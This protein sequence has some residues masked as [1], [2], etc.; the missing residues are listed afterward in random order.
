M[1]VFP[2]GESGPPALELALVA[3]DLDWRGALGLDAV[4][5]EQDAAE[6]AA[7]LAGAGVDGL[8]YVTQQSEGRCRLRAL[9]IPSLEWAKEPPEDEGFCRFTVEDDGALHPGGARGVAATPSGRLT[10]VL[11]GELFA[12]YPGDRSELLLSAARLEEIV[13]S[14]AA[15]EEVAW[16]DDERFWAVV[17]TGESATVALMTAHGLLGAPWFGAPSVSGLQLSSGGMAAVSSDRGV[18]FFDRGGRRV[19][20]FTNGRDV[21]W[22]P[23][24]VIA[25]ISTPREVIFV[26]PL[27]GEVVTVPFQVRDL[28]WVA[29]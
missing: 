4:P 3:N 15:L 25:A 23:G 24:E 6:A 20:T 27:S 1:F 2:P 29:E 21:T 12:G 13:G 16:V 22:A 26:A 17:R 14:P 19:L 7:F 10:H 5:A 9:E 18:V 11:D 8:L 28:E